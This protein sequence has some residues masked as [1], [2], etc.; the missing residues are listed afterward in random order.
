MRR[1]CKIDGCSN[2]RK[3][4]GLCEKHYMQEYRSNKNFNK[5]TDIERFEGNFIKKDGCWEW[6]NPMKSGY[7]SFMIKHKSM[8]ASRASYLLYVGEIPK[9]LYVCHT[10]DNR[11][12]VNPEHLFLGTALENSQDMVAKNRQAKGSLNGNS[13]LLEKQVLEIRNNK[14]GLSSRKLG[15]LYNVSKTTILNILN[16]KQWR[17]V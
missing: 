1:I 5:I 4:H 10:C 3:G 7:G 6:N 9:G 12:C 13:R 17:Y 8:F 11:C 14:L 2:V 16:N 15:E